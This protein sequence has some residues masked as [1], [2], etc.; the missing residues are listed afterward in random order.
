MYQ[1]L[2]LIF[3]CLKQFRIFIALMIGTGLLNLSSAHA[4]DI[5]DPPKSDRAYTQLI[6]AIEEFKL[7]DLYP[8]HTFQG[9]RAFTRYE[10]A[11]ALFRVQNYLHAKYQIHLSQ[12]PRVTSMLQ[13]YLKPLGDIPQRHWAIQALRQSMAYGLLTGDHNLKFHG[14][15]KVSRYQ[16]AQSLYQVFDWLQIHP[17]V[18]Q[19]PLKALD[20]HKSHWASQ[21]V[22]EVL[23]TQIMQTDQDGHFHGERF[24]TRQELANAMVKVMQQI[25]LVAL[26]DGLHP[27][28]IIPLPGILIRKRYDGKLPPLHYSESE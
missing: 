27:K 26:R 8:D 24:A 20:L 18:T 12:D 3:T 21:A 23:I 11:D 5:V 22:H 7:L 25:E 13:S 14:A 10:L 28:E 16:L 1:R 4:L 9:E 17:I 6:L 19:R 2:M 15:L